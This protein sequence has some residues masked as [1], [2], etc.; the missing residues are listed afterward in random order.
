MRKYDP[1]P[2]EKIEAA[3]ERISGDIV[4]PPLVRLDFDDAPAEIYLKLENLQPI[5]AFKIRGGV[6]ALK[7]TDREMLKNGV[8]AISAGNWAQGLAWASRKMGVKCT[9]LV[10][11]GIPETKERA[12]ASHGT[13]ST[14]SREPE[15][16][17]AWR[18]FSFTRSATLP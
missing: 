13:R 10:P 17:R 16:G 3:R 18:G 6:N 12:R 9:I 2:L 5:R 15:A 7:L 14:R 8:W 4:R 11:E 1:T